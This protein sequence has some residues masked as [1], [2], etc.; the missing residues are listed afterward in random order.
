MKKYLYFNNIIE[1]IVRSIISKPI[2]ANGDSAKGFIVWLFTLAL[3]LEA[4]MYTFDI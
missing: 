3:T 4:T 2:N 1:A